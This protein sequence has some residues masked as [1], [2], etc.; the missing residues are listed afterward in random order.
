VW[1]SVLHISR[2]GVNDNFFV[3][4]GNSL[5]A[6][7]MVA[8]LYDQ[9]N[10]K[11]AITTLYQY[12][13]LKDLARFLG[14]ESDISTI[15]MRRIEPADRDE[16]AI[17]GMS[18][19]FPGARSIDEYWNVLRNGKETTRFFDDSELDPSIPLSLRTHP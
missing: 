17:I 10:I 19:R 14:G 5:L 12:P 4:G 2:V 7:K 6:Q 11:L 9:H 1:A 15:G 18:C 3:L 16:I 13:I 8:T